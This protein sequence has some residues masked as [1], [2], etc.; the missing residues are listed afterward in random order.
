MNHLETNAFKPC[1]KGE[2]GVLFISTGNNMACQ[3]II[4][5]GKPIA[6]NLARLKLKGIKAIQEL[7]RV[8]IRGATF[9]DGIKI[10]YKNVE[11]I[12][13]GDVALNLLGYSC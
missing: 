8:G 6:A 4:E 10:R 11:R 1:I 3:V 5:D 9:R 12:E 7:K 13:Q 2:S